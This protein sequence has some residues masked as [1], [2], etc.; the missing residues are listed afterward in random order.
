MQGK[1]LLH[2]NHNFNVNWECD[3]QSSSRQQRDSNR[4]KVITARRLTSDWMNSVELTS[5]E[6][7]QLSP[8]TRNSFNK[9]N[10]SLLQAASRISAPARHYGISLLWDLRN[11]IRSFHRCNGRSA[12]LS[13]QVLLYKDFILKRWMYWVTS[14]AVALHCCNAHA[15]INR[16]MGNSTPHTCK[17][18]TSENI[19][20][21]LCI[22]DYSATWPTVQI[23]DLIDAVGT[24]PQIGEIL[25]PCD[26]FDC[27]VACYVLYRSCGC[28][29]ALAALSA[30]RLNS[31]RRSVSN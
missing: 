3:R 10:T 9:L 13:A 1:R 21:K 24:S 29:T 28:A 23:L 6:C 8:A 19:I 5:T 22:R 30:L 25:P 4:K 15:K 17:I 20:L 18:V 27:P 26:F 14:S 7:L 12:A 2:F 16:Q 31:G 11:R